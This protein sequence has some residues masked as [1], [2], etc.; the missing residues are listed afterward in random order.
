MKRMNH[1]VMAL[2]ALLLALAGCRQ[3]RRLVQIFKIGLEAE[4]VTLDPHLN[5][6]SATWTVLGNMFEGLVGF[7]REMR[8]I[9]LLAESWENPDEHTWLFRLR[10]DVLF[11]NGDLFTSD[12]A[13]YSLLRARNHTRS[14]IQTALTGVSGITAKDPY[15]I[16]INTID[17]NPILLNKLVSVYMLSKKAAQASDDSILAG[18]PVGTGPYQFEKW[19]KQ[20][21][22][23]LVKNAGYW[24]KPALVER[25]I[26]KEVRL[27]QE[28]GKALLSGEVDLIRGVPSDAF[29]S[30]RRDSRTKLIL[31]PGLTV[32]YLG[33]DLTGKCPAFRELRVRQAVYAGIDIEDIIR[34]QMH[35]YGTAS[36]QL[37]SPGIFGYNPE[38]IRP[39]CDTAKA[40]IL[41]Q[42]AGYKKGFAVTLDVPENAKGVGEDIALALDKIGIRVS[43]AITPW[44]AFY[45]KITKGQSAFFL[46]GWNCTGGD[47]S[48]FYDACLH[49]PNRVLGYGSAN[50]GKYSSR[51]MD[52]LIEQSNQTIYPRQ[53]Q[54]YLQ[55]IMKLAMDELP[56][57]P[58]YTQDTFYGGR[59][60]I[61]WTPRLDERI[62]AAEIQIRSARIDDIF[63]SK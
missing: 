33:F 15:T 38:I 36:G 60:E 10:R 51:R 55:D 23:T 62:Y 59:K 42:M 44:G 50:L 30:I 52:F 25:V 5:G 47:A 22:V 14:I 20:A 46:V 9:P 27:R 41:L 12:D 8:I 43:L 37:V 45:K 39:P 4:P 53:R 49:S 40:K 61:M 6:E 48:D 19:E 7:D 2:L 13:V 1:A 58:L 31:G 24:G 17:P 28:R 54:I 26:F 11:H 35:G 57:I 18:K 56:L 32:S 29:D 16:V 21:G 63:K 34:R 3:E